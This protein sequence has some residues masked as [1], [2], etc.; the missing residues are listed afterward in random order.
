MNSLSQVDSLLQ[1]WTSLMSGERG[2][3]KQMNVLGPLKI[4]YGSA[5]TGEAIFFSKSTVK[6]H[7]PRVSSTIDVEVRR[8]QDGDWVQ[9]FLLRDNRFIDVFMHLAWSM[10]DACAQAV[11]EASALTALVHELEQWRRLLSFH[12][13]DRLSLSQIRGLYAE[14][15]FATNILSEQYLPGEVLDAWGGPKMADQDFASPLPAAYEIKAVYPNAASVRIS[16]ERQL[17]ALDLPLTLNLVVL[18]EVPNGENLLG[19]SLLNAID[20]F[21]G[22]LGGDPMRIQQ[23]NELLENDLKVDRSDDFYRGFRF[24][25]RGVKVYEVTAAF[26]AIRASEISPALGPVDYSISIPAI[27]SFE[28]FLA[29]SSLSPGAPD[30]NS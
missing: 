11:D 10:A 3:Q 5:A 29:D 24:R 28:T 23:L 9:I 19:Q 27:S 17:D 25:V 7:V 14:I 21:E 16:S 13:D 8:R 26:P 6:P 30:G 22:V 15:W 2:R 20:E 12:K 18:E 4:Y 1:E